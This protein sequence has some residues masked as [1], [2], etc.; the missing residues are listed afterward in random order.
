M[1][2]GAGVPGEDEHAAEDH[3]PQQF[4]QD[5]KE[6]EILAGDL[7]QDEQHQ[8]EPEQLRPTQDGVALAGGDV[9][10]VCGNRLGH[11]RV[12]ACA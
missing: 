1:R 5:V 8:P 12:V 6:Q 10:A 7:V 2:P 3:D 11:G 4:A 9:A